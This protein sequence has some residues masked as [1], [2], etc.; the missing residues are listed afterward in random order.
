MKPLSFLNPDPQEASPQYLEDLA[1]AYWFSEALFTAVEM[2][3]FTFLEPM[4]K[5]I[6]EI[7]S[8]L[9]SDCQGV[10]RFL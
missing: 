4:G 10:E 9:E 7:A 1:T 8:A 3:I 5:T 2:G 6:A